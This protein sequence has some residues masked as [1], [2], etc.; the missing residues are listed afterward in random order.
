MSGAIGYLLFRSGWNRIR[1]IASE[2]RK[3]GPRIAA[4]AALGYFVFLAWLSPRGGG[5]THDTQVAMVVGALGLMVLVLSAWLLGTGGR[6]VELTPAERALLLPAPISTARVMDV[7]L[8]RL[9]ATALGNAVLWTALTSGGQHWDTI[10]RRAMAFWLVITTLQ[11]HRIGAARSRAGAAIHPALRRIL[12][13]FGIGLVALVP[14]V[15]SGAIRESAP[16]LTAFLGE[17]S[18][19]PLARAVLLPFVLVL[20]PLT[21][22]SFG[23]WAAAL[24][25]ALAMLLLH[26]LWVRRL[27][28]ELEREPDPL[29]SPKGA[30]MWMLAPTGT[31]AGAFFWKNVTALVRRS[32][33]LLAVGAAGAVVML[34]VALRSAG[35]VG[36]SEFLGWMLLMW[37]LLL[38]LMGP[39][40]VRND[41]RRDQGMLALLRTLPVRG[42]DVILG[43]SVAAALTLASAVIAL[44]V[45]GAVAT[46][47]SHQPPLPSGNRGVWLGAAILVIG[48]L[49]LAGILLQN[50]AVILLPA[51]SRM[52]ARRGTATALGTNLANSALTI[53]LLMV[54]AVLPVTLALLVWRAA[55]GAWL[56]VASAFVSAVVL[57][58]ECWAMVKWL[59]MRFENIDAST[60]AALD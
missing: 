52:T 32:T 46:A 45:A 30:P 11:L 53:L 38:L 48:P 44:L 9:Q 10:G 35:R 26:Y 25:P 28:P 13:L 15:L 57:S 2:F 59:G 7:K 33:A 36:A 24:G 17:L 41:L 20:R 12:G 60:R 21:A 47:G 6:L 54:L 37:S 49:A 29:T 18:M 50:A 56:P 19:S 27:G 55:E 1:R 51:W 8:I 22:A 42:Y 39:Q 43:S 5:G 14:V 16:G 58:A 34:P 31:A 4:V 23:E 3:P 40:F